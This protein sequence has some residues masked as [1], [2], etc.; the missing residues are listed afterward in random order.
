MAQ[1]VLRRGGLAGFVA[2]RLQISCEYAPSSRLAI[3]PDAL[4]IRCPIYFQNTLLGLLFSGIL[5]ADGSFAETVNFDDAKSGALPS[6]W[7]A[8]ITGPGDFNW[9][10]EADDSAPS[11]PNVLKQSGRVPSHSFPWCVKKDAS[12]KDGFVQVRMKSVDGTED[13]AGGVVWRWQDGDNYYVARANALE[14]NVTIYHTVKGVRMECGRAPAKVAPHEWHTLRVDFHGTHYVLTIDGVKALEWEDDT[15]KNAGAVG[16]WT[17][18]DS[19][20]EFDDFTFGA[21]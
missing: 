10:V 15:F 19:V 4:G 14:D 5:F 9:A 16:L 7:Q 21:E 18:S 17:K 8:G 2:P 20:M 11:K 6:D 13:Q 1:S 3:Q 12:L